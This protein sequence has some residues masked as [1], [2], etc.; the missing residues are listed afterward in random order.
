MNTIIG[1]ALAAFAPG[2]LNRGGFGWGGYGA[3]APAAVATATAGV[4]TA[5]LTAM[6]AG[7][8]GGYSNTALLEKDYQNR[9]ASIH[10]DNHLAKQICMLGE[11]VTKVETIQPYAA[12]IA[13]LEQKL[14]FNTLKDYVDRKDCRNIKGMV[15]LVQPTTL[16]TFI[17]S[18]C[19]CAE[20]EIAA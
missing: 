12:K 4:E 14:A 1:T 15:G 13:E 8:N 17:P 19:K 5:L 18:D 10:D 16:P 3:G 20:I 6:L 11:R 9:I 2:F 7:H